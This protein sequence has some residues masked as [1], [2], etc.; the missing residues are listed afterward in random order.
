[1]TRKAI[2]AW[3]L[4]GLALLSM[5]A[6]GALEIFAKGSVS[7]SNITSDTNTISVSASTGIA[8]TLIPRV[9]LEARYT[10]VSSLQNKLEVKSTTVVGTINDMKTQTTIYSLGLDIDI[11]GKKSAFQPFIF[12][13]AGYLQTDRSYY[14]TLAGETEAVYAQDPKQS[15]VSGN[16]GAG[17]RILLS[18]SFAFEVEVFAY[19]VDID[20][21][22]PLVNL[23]G[24][25]GFRLFM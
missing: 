1:M 16:L 13:G 7:K 19:G 2:A 20:K 4:A 22:E 25:V 15:G 11:L 5:P 8:I 24:T 21:P 10:N 14:F 23:Y 18:N 3:F 6:H 9:R 12:V 17:F